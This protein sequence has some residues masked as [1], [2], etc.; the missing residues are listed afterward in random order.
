MDTTPS[1][2][3]Y[4]QISTDISYEQKSYVFSSTQ[5]VDKYWC[6]L[7]TTSVCTQLGGKAGQEGKEIVLENLENK[8]A[9]QEACKVC[10]PIQALIY[11]DGSIPGDH[12][13][14]SGLDSAFFAHLKRNWCSKYLVLNSSQ[15]LKEQMANTLSWEGDFSTEPKGMAE[16]EEETETNENEKEGEIKKN[17][18][19]IKKVLEFEDTPEAP[20]PGPSGI[21]KKPTFLPRPRPGENRIKKRQIRKTRYKKKVDEESDIQHFYRG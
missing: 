15:I 3:G 18:K 4:F 17:N 13:G 8:I 11:D 6:D 5:D 19:N 20:K 16:E 2:I 12:L 1:K 9:M 10:N 14:A 7:F 21:K